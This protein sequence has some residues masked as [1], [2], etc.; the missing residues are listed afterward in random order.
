[1]APRLKFFAIGVV[2]S[3]KEGLE[4]LFQMQYKAGNRGYLHTASINLVGF[5]IRRK[6]PVVLIG[7]NI[8][9]EF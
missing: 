4:Y 7:P 9:F 3:R 6:F 8:T 1:M 5:A 2:K